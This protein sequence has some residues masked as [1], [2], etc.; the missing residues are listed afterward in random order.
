MLDSREVTDARRP[1]PPPSAGGPHRLP[2][3]I[4]LLV[5]GAVLHSTVASAQSPDSTSAAADSLGIQLQ[6]FL[7]ENESVRSIAGGVVV[8]GR[9][10]TAARGVLSDS[11]AAA[12]PASIYPIGSITKA[13]VGLVLADRET[14]GRL[15]PADPVAS[16]LPDS[17]SLAAGDTAAVTL[18]QLVTHTSGLPRLP[19]NLDEPSEFV[20]LFDPYAAY[21]MTDLFAAIDTASFDRAPGTAYAYSNFGFGLL[22]A[23]LAREAGVSFDSMIAATITGPLGLDDT[24]TTLL[25]ATDGRIATGYAA[26][27]KMM[28]VWQFTD[29]MA[30]LGALHSTVDDMLTFLGAQADPATAGDLADAIRLSH[31]RLHDADNDRWDVA[32]GWH[33][34]QYEGRRMLWHSGGTYGGKSFAAFAPD[35]NA[36]VVLLTNTGLGQPATSAFQRLALQILDA[37]IDK[38]GN[39][40]NASPAE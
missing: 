24:H 6:A 22:G 18:G 30:G 13:F 2:V 39:T 20:N 32:Y 35:H 4:A 26:D 17:L 11:G 37:A 27:G 23:A 40:P 1:V 12:S 33:I 8:D 38:R 31:T 19:D 9:R 15:S 3:L 29:A 14:K 36:G 10:T 25:D 5:F 16:L 28:P 7:D 34:L 21:R